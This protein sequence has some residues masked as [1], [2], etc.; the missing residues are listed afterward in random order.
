M[1]LFCEA[2]GR[3]TPKITWTRVLQDGSD[4]EVL[5]HGQTWDFLNIGRTA[6]GTYRCTA[7]NKF[8]NVSQEF[9]VNV[10]CKYFNH[11][12]KTLLVI[13]KLNIKNDLGL[14]N[15]PRAK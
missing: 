12:S 4:G 15:Q 5:H 2:T 1:T 3:P 10:T 13:K 6:S 14:S 7:G 11:V 9:Q 8:E